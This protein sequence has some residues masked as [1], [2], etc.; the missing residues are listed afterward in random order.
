MWDCLL[1]N[2]FFFLL[3]VK[4]INDDNGSD[5]IFYYS[6]NKS[7]KRTETRNCADRIHAR[8][9]FKCSIRDDNWT[10]LSYFWGE[11]LDT[12]AEKWFHCCDHSILLWKKVV[13]ITHQKLS[14]Y[15]KI[16]ECMRT[17]AKIR[18]SKQNETQ[19]S[20]EHLQNFKWKSLRFYR[21]NK[22]NTRKTST[23]NV[24]QFK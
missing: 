12:F 3:L 13:L 15:K 16:M 18:I 1:F 8:K 21:L 2:T 11:S 24:M 9:M 5:D 17:P 6:K 7:F 22:E 14:K 4:Q 10:W 20:Y 23:F 19:F